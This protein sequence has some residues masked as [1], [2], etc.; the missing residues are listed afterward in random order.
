MEEHNVRKLQSKILSNQW[1]YDYDY[2]CEECNRLF[3]GVM[4]S[5]FLLAMIKTHAGKLTGNV[6]SFLQPS[7]F[8]KKIKSTYT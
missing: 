2:D 4:H 8:I 3:G 1:G 5:P 6:F 7:Y